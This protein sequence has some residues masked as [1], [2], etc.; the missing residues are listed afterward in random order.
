MVVAIYSTA[1]SEKSIDIY[2]SLS[3]NFVFLFYDWLKTIEREKIKT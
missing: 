3:Y 2:T 1:Q